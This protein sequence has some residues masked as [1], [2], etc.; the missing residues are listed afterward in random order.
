MSLLDVLSQ[1]KGLELVVAHFNHGIRREAGSDEDFVRDKAARYNMTF[2]SAQGGLGV[3]ASEE[4]ARDVRYQF[5]REMK[6][7][8]EAEAIIT[9]H[10]Q[11]DLIE[12]ALINVLRGTGPKGLIAISVNKEIIRPLLKYTKNDI[13]A[14]AKA[15]ELKWVEDATNQDNDILRNY[16]RNEVLKQ[17]RE[18]DRQ[19]IIEQIRNIELVNSETED[20]IANLSHKILINGTTLNRAAF[21]SLPTEVSSRFLMYWLRKLEVDNLDRVTVLRLVN[22]LKTAPAGSLHEVK[23]GTRIR[24][25]KKEANFTHY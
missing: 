11:D 8:H 13:L 18:T 21:I 22:A 19:K 14:Y 25:S 4:K 24:I 20:I 12:T 7:K 17:L 3:K 5:L 6:Q 15:H 16:I 1:Q 2:E 10:H 9:A 23:K